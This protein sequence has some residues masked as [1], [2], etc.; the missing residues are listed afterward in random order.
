MKERLTSNQKVEELFKNG[1]YKLNTLRSRA[2]LIGKAPKLFKR[3][4]YLPKD[5]KKS[6][7]SKDKKR[8]IIR[9]MKKTAY[10]LNATTEV[11]REGFAELHN[12]VFD[13]FTKPTELRKI[14]ERYK[15]FIVED[16]K[17]RIVASAVIEPSP[18]NMDVVWHLIVVSPKLRGRGIFNN[19]AVYTDKYIKESGADYAS[20][21]ASTF[22]IENQ[23]VFERLGFNIIGIYSGL[24]IAP[25][26]D[27]T[28]NRQPVTIYEKWYKPEKNFLPVRFNLT[29]RGKYLKNQIKICN[30]IK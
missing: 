3:K 16:E 7:M 8:Y 9:Y 15:I 1:V 2:S 5:M 13:A 17:K 28:Y 21:I 29:P 14:A 24:I 26:G 30:K 18:V 4:L 6:F 23:I 20:L 10:D 19:L 25:N 12:S 11:F 22:Q 27:G